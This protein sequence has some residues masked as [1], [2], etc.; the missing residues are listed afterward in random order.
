MIKTIEAAGFEAY[1]VGGCVRDSIL[2]RLPEDWDLTSNASRDTLEALFPDAAIVNQKLG[3]MRI[4]EGEVTADIAAYRI[5]GEYKDYRR[6]DTVVFTNDIGEDL[7]RRDFTMN[8]IAVS[9][10]RGVV[11]PFHGRTDIERKRIRGIGDPRL[12]FEEDALRILR[13]IRFAAQLGFEIDDETLQAMKERADLLKH[14]SV[15]RIREEFV[16]TITAEYSGKGLGLLLETGVLTYIA[17]EESGKNVSND[18]LDR[19]ALLAERIDLADREPELRLA[20]F[21]QCLDRDRALAAIDHLAYSNERRRLLR[22]SVSLMKE[23]EGIRE[24]VELKKWI[25]GQGLETYF[26]LTELSIQRSKVYR[27]DKANLQSRIGLYES[28]RSNGEPVFIEDLAVNGKD[29][30]GIGIK[31]GIKIGKILHL[32]LAFVHRFPEKNKK[33]QLLVIAEDILKNR[34]D[35]L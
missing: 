13:A 1:A 10:G 11:D 16:K 28:I 29:L 21:Y 30:I 8:A 17:G 22:Y 25:A 9:P 20:L 5:D 33:D 12:R 3:V 14:I 23:L 24:R 26:F 6:P 34:T 2:G 19:L 27:L 32:L 35:S 7:K 15:E 31:E 4:T 18:D